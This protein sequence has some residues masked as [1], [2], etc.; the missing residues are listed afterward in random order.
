MSKV[1]LRIDELLK[2]RGLT[3]QE[4]SR[5]TGIRQAAISEMVRNKRQKISIHHL[6]KIA[7]ALGITDVN[8]LLTIEEE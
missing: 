5:L 8:E 1:R 7:K 4:L 2:N 3:Q 6:E